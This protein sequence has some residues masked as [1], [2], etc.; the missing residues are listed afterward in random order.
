M[1]FAMDTGIPRLRTALRDLVALSTIPAAWVGRD[2]AAIAAGLADV[3]ISSLQLDFAFVRLCEPGADT[4]FEVSRGTAWPGFREWLGD[5]L[6]RLG[7][8]SHRE[9][10]SNVGGPTMSRRGIVIPIG[11]DGQGGLVAA[12]SDRSDFPGEIDQLLLSVAANHAATAVQHARA[13]LE[14]KSAEAAVRLAR[15]DLEQKVA[16]RTAELR[17]AGEDRLEHLRFLQSLDRVNRAIQGT[18]DLEQM[19]SD[20]LDVV[21]SIFDADRA[22]L[23]YPCDSTASSVRVVM[24]HTRREFPGAFALGDALPVDDELANGLRLATASSEPVRFDPRSEH[25]LPPNVARRFAIQSMIAMAVY[26]K[27]EAPYLFG[28]HQC[29]HPRIWTLQDQRLFQEIGRR[30]SD[31]LTTLLIFRNLRVSERRLA[32]AQRIAHVAYWDWDLDSDQT[33]WSDESFRI[34]GRT[35]GGHSMTVR[36]VKAMVHPEDLPPMLQIFDAALAG[37]PRFDMEW[38]LVRPNGELR[39]IHSQCD[40]VR[41]ESGRARHVFGTLQDI[42]ERRQA[43]RLTR[44]IFETSPDAVYVIDRD[45][46]IRRINAACARDW[47]VRA[48]S[49]VGMPFAEF[50]GREQF[51]ERLKSP[52]DRCFTGEQVAYATWLDLP[53]GR[54][55]RSGIFAPLRSTGLD[56]IDGV[57]LIVRDLTDYMAASEALQKAHAELA[58]GTRLAMLGEITASI[59]HEVA[60]PLVGVVMNGNACHHWLAADPPNLDEARDSVT[61]ILADAERAGRIIQGIRALA[62]RDDVDRRDLDVN[63]VIH[64][65]LE[66]THAE[67]VQKRV[68]IHT[69]LRS[70]LPP[71]RGDRVQLQQ[72]LVNLLLNA[73]DAMVDLPPERRTVTVTSRQDASGVLVEVKDCGAGIEPAHAARMFD[74]FFTTKVSGLGLGL[75]ISRSIVQAHGG[76]I[77][78]APSDDRGTAMYF[79]LPAALASEATGMG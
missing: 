3:L 54:R 58:Q 33:I 41:D 71:I 27:E 10:V 45:Y 34:F 32:D 29:S 11:V 51:D 74:A 40:I 24:E 70:A 13:L 22:W 9:I 38:R 60:Q 65:A 23:L 73:G 18:N 64:E 66:F 16:E 26:P 31:G 15:D 4:A 52:L 61:R 35:P 5:H 50:V 49:V 77:W 62:R 8:L 42:T 46:R 6:A 17:K 47:Q 59:A 53:I 76:R 57:L 78:A 44:Q 7:T 43:E 56:E 21:L 67:L 68:I 1:A 2:P 55:Y 37:G 20:V 79:V 28:L 30:L 69:N 14:R 19:M 75:A 63:D 48:D 25:R 72:V 39:I 12:A 36:E